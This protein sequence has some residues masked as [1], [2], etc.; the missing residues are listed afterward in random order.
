MSR[1][2]RRNATLLPTSADRLLLLH[3]AVVQDVLLKHVSPEV[4]IHLSHRL[5]SYAHT[6]DAAQ[7]IQLNF[8][9]GQVARC[10]LLIAAD[11]VHSTVR[12]Q[13]LPRLAEK[14]GKPDLLE[15]VDPLFSGS[16][17]YRNLVPTEKL[18]AVWPNHPALTKPRSVRYPFLNDSLVT[19]P[20]FDLVLWQEQ[21]IPLHT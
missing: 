4:K 18:A 10:D 20:S 13:F 11:G 14:L 3:R 5:E 19:D 15:S 9:N 21:G 1:S 7:R 12:R 17:A 16:K 8:K 6:E 2:P